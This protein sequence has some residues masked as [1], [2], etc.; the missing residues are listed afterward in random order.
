M[1]TIAE[2]ASY[3]LLTLPNVH[4]Q[5][6]NQRN[7]KAVFIVL[8]LDQYT[9]PLDPVSPVNLVLYDDGRRSYTFQSNQQQGTITIPALSEDQ[10]QLAED[11]ETFDQI[12][13]QYAD[14]RWKTQSEV[15]AGLG[16]EYTRVREG[17]HVDDSALRGHLVLMDEA[18]GEVV[19]EVP[20]KLNVREDPSVSSSQDRKDGEKGPVLLELPPD[21]YDAYTGEGNGV[22]QPPKARREEGEEYVEAKEIFVRA[23]PPEEQDWMTKSAHVISQAL[24]TSTSLLITGITS[25]SK[26]YISHSKPYTPPP[27]SRTS[28][29]SSSTSSPSRSTPTSPTPPSAHPALTKAHALTGQA[30]RASAKTADLVESMIRRAVGGKPKISPSSSASGSGLGG[31]LPPAPVITSPGYKVYTPKG[32]GAASPTS[33]YLGAGTPPP[34]PPRSRNASAEKLPLDTSRPGTPNT[35]VTQEDQQPKKAGRKEKLMLSANL[36]LSAVDDSVSRVFEVGSEQLSAVVGHKYGPQAGHSTHLATHTARNVTLVYVDM[37]G[38]A[39]RAL[40][41]KA[42]KEWVKA[43]V[44]SNKDAVHN[45]LE[46]SNKHSETYGTSSLEGKPIPGTHRQQSH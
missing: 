32:K 15:D 43:R 30:A 5:L 27:A 14:L 31:G 23:I 41:K 18:S 7:D 33:Q 11:I 4:L 10:T 38:F 16:H 8:H 35:G 39:R 19:A 6:V 29:A 17:Q 45:T 42:G 9:F 22:W 1:S 44:G 37:R 28:S 13:S 40:I 21:V 12:L 20:Q 36:V 25:A 34:L 24:S 2:P 26:Y 46:R 3:T